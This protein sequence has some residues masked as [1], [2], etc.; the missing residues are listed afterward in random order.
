MKYK[1]CVADS[2]IE[3][4]TWVNRAIAEGWLPQGGVAVSQSPPDIDLLSS[5]DEDGDDDA[6]E[7]EPAFR[8]HVWA[9]A[10][11]KNA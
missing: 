4:D 2:A 6:P 10:M 7:N 8:T 3:L 9:Q 11:I 1:I 5:E